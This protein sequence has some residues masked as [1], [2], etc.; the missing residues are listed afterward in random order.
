MRSGSCSLSTMIRTKR[1]I[2]QTL[3]AVILSAATIFWQHFALAAEPVSTNGQALQAKY[4]T[5]IPRLAKN[6]FGIPLYLESTEE[7]NS[8]HVDIYGIFAFPFAQVRDALK[9]PDNWCVINILLCYIMAAT[10][11]KASSH[12]LLTLYSGR[13][14]YQLP[15][16]AFKLDLNFHI[17][18]AQEEYLNI[19]L[20]GENGPLGTRDHRIKFEATPLEKDRP[21]I[22]F[23]Y[24]YSFGILARAAMASYYKTIGHDKKGFSVSATDKKGDPV[25][26]NGARGSL[27]RTAIRSYFAIQAYMEA[28]DIPDNQQ[29]EKRLNHWYDLTSQFPQQLYEMDKGDYL[30]NKRREHHNQLILQEKL[31]N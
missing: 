1:F 7:S 18:A 13:K 10:F 15:Q 3:L 6:Q 24:D 9:K 27:E 23:R 4:S 29:F 19:E 21:F 30:A 22:H 14:Y 5:L 17:A 31:A 12:W 16:N 20:S 11:S 2:I 8:L 25:Y 26:I 28:L